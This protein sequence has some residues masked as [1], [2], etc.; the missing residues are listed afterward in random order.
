MEP[1]VATYYTMLVATVFAA[2]WRGKSVEKAGAWIALSGSLFTSTVAWGGIWEA[3]A[4]PVFII[5]LLVLAGFWSL[6][7]FSSRFWPYWATG[8]QLVGLLVHIQRLMFD[9]ILEKPYGLLSMYIAYPIL[10]VILL[11]SL[12]CGTVANVQGNLSRR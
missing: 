11:S 1:H 6:A 8:W 10:L 2:H 3:F 5:D 7:L 9:D 12:Q 4:V